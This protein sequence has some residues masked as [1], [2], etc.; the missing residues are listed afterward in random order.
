LVIWKL[1]ILSISIPLGVTCLVALMVS[2]L[3][4]K[5]NLR[6][7]CYISLIFSLTMAVLY[8]LSHLDNYTTLPSVLQLF[9]EFLLLPTIFT[10]LISVKYGGKKVNRIHNMMFYSRHKKGDHINQDRIEW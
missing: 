4:F 9:T 10:I 8:L 3:R 6:S 2:L 7:L 1:L 5:F